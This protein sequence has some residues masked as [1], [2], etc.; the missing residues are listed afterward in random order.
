MRHVLRGT[1]EEAMNCDDL[2]RRYQELQQYVGW[3]DEDAE[4][5]HS[6]A[7]SPPAKG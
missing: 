6:V 2:F 3:T 5:V 7:V 4:R 1:G